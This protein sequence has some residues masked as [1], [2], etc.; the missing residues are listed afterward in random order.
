MSI[1]QDVAAILDSKPGWFGRALAPGDPVQQP[2]AQGRVE[3]CVHK[4]GVE[5]H[6]AQTL[7]RFVRESRASWLA[8]VLFETHQ[9]DKRYKDENWLMLS[10]EEHEAH[11]AEE[12]RKYTESLASRSPAHKNYVTYYTSFGAAIVRDLIEQPE[13]HGFT[14]GAIVAPRSSWWNS[15][16]DKWSSNDIAI[17]EHMGIDTRFCEPV[18]PYDGTGRIGRFYNDTDGYGYPT[19]LDGRMVATTVGRTREGTQLGVFSGNIHLDGPD[20]VVSERLVITDMRCFALGV[21]C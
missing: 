17:M 1:D 16:V 15:G 6:S 8:D 9:P 7:A 5:G 4:F 14:T 10:P 19:L 21:R 18:N 3:G 2:N 11:Y 13:T 20:L 12:R